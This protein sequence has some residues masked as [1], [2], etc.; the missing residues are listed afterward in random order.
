M[1]GLRI[2]TQQQV[3]I[4]QA[5]YDVGRG[6]K[7][8][9]NEN[10]AGTVDYTTV[11]SA[12]ATQLSTEQTALSVRESRLIDSVTLIGD[13][14]GGWSAESLCDPRGGRCGE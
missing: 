8:A 13:L 7:V 2:L 14:G 12:Q 6:A 1:S 4:D 5:V 11:A 10:Q 9:L 3:V